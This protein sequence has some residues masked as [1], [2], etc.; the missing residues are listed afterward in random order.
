VIETLLS[1]QFAQ[2]EKFSIPYFGLFWNEIREAYPGHAIKPPL[3]QQVE[4]FGA[5]PGPPTLGFAITQ[6]P[7]ARCWFISR[8]DDQLIQVQRDRF[9]R[10]WRKGPQT[11]EYPEYSVLRP[12]F[13]A[14]WLR[15]VRFLEREQ[16]GRPE[17][18]QCEVSYINH[19]PIGAGESSFGKLEGVLK[20]LSDN[21]N[22]GFL[23][24]PEILVLNTS[25]IMHDKRG[26]LYVSLNPA[27]RLDDGERVLQL[28]LTAR[29]R[30]ASTSHADVMAWLDLGHEW[31][32]NSFADLTTR[33][34]HDRWERYR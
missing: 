30:P 9:I 19:I 21:P 29:G 34:M 15:F 12:R 20:I 31:V 16:L 26:R 33:S 5:P 6:E 2:L 24:E 1:V 28:T 3:G 22:R 23:P 8:E 32:V 11:P 4:Q 27:I 25:Y 10:N 7:L 13:E 17:V 14:D 18:N